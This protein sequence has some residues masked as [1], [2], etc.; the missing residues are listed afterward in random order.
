MILYIAR[1]GETSW[2]REGR[3]QG[4]L[5]SEL[6]ALGEEQA[7]ALGTALGSRT[8]DAVYASPLTRCLATANALG[9]PVIADARLI[10]IAHGTWEGR[11]R[12]EIERSDAPRFHAWRTQPQSVSFDGGESLHQVLLRWRSFLSSLAATPA[13]AIAIVTHDVIVRLAILDAS[14]RGAAQLW[15]PRVVNGGYAV[16][17]KTDTGWRVREEC[18]DTHLCGLLVDTA[19]QAL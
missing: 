5:E 4:Q 2:N 17:E 16:L 3:Y 14:E 12:D 11:L 7:R 10:E 8:L 6:T 18:V 1:H 19:Q 9:R 13:G 15:E